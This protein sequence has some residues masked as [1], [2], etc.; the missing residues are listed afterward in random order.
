MK[1]VTW[2]E[3]LPMNL[4][5]VT[6]ACFEPT[7]TM[8]T[9]VFFP[10]QAEVMLVRKVCFSLS[11]TTVS[12]CSLTNERRP[13]THLFGQWRVWISRPCCLSET[14]PHIH[15]D[16]LRECVMRWGSTSAHCEF[17]LQ[18]P[19]HF[20][21]SNGLKVEESPSPESVWERVCVCV[22]SESEPICLCGLAAVE[23][24]PDRQ[25]GLH[26]WWASTTEQAGRQLRQETRSQT[27]WDRKRQGVAFEIKAQNLSHLKRYKG[28]LCGR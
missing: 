2:T 21:E 6:L 24:A 17:P 14:Q 7:W 26:F 16:E 10:W 23:S 1:F 22:P 25:A 20:Q 9:A 3:T 18:K 19:A 15:A 5:R 8:K 4:T 13:W 12:L 11:W 27:G 28:K